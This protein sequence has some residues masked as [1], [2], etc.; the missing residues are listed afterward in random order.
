[1]IEGG[2]FCGNVRYSVNDGDHR[3]AN[4]HCSMCRKTSAAAYVTW[5]VVPRSD[6]TYTQGEPAVLNSSAH[7]TRHFCN[8]CGTPLLFFEKDRPDT[9]D[10]TVGSLDEPEKFPPAKNVFEESRLSWVVTP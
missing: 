8:Q 1:M 6:F 9:Y 7:A 4:C 2:C 5:M 3:V 10:V